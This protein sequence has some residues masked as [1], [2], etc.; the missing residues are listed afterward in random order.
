MNVGSRLG[1]RLSRATVGRVV[2]TVPPA[3][4]SFGPPAC[5][6]GVETR[7]G[8]TI[9]RLKITKLDAARRQLD[10]A[11]ALYFNDGDEI[12]RPNP[13]QKIRTGGERFAGLELS[14]LPV[15]VPEATNQKRGGL[16]DDIKAWKREEWNAIRLRVEGDIPH[17][18]MW[19]NDALV[20]D[21]TDVK[22]SAVDWM[23]EAPIAIQVHG[24][25]RW[26]PGGF[27]SRPLVR[28]PIQ[29]LAVKS[30]SRAPRYSRICL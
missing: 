17:V 14:P 2:F 6:C 1:E 4:P 7:R 3:A 20:T 10:S 12:G 8:S 30:T 29:S 27:C 5:R 22:N 16:F 15:K 25:L 23:W 13:T 11:I 28:G 18:Q 24:L 21:F 26:R 19:V 9:H